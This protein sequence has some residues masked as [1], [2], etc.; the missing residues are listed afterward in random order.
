MMRKLAIAAVTTFTFAAAAVSAHAAP[1]SQTA[2][3]SAA[4]STP[5]IAVSNHGVCIKHQC[6]GRNRIVCGC[7]QG[8][9]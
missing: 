8:A 4:T 2:W 1:A 6:P 5:V 7:P 9:R 3:G